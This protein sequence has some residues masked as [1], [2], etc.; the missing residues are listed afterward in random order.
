MQSNLP[1]NI[2]KIQKAFGNMDKLPKA[3][4][5]YGCYAVFIIYTIGVVLIL[6]NNTVLPYNP[7]YDFISKSIVKTS[8]TLFAEAIIGGLIMDF[9]FKR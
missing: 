2:R 4:I 5:K 1:E 8:F 9:V 6:L 3:L 7:Y